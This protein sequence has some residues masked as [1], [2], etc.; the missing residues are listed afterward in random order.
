MNE[1][2]ISLPYK[3]ML[4][5]CRFVFR[6]FTK[7][8]AKGLEQTPMEGPL[9]IASNHISIFE[10]P[11]IFA[12]IPRQPVSTIAKAEYRDWIVSRLFFKGVDPVYVTRG[13]ADRTALKEILNRLKNKQALGIAP[14]GTRSK[15]KALIQ[16]KEGTAYLA[17][18]SGA[19]ILPLAVWGQEKIL[20][21]WTR[22]R[23]PT[24]YIRAAKPFKVENNPNKTRQENLAVNTEQLMHAIA[25]LLPPEYRG[26][27]AEA[28]QG[29]PEW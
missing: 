26:Y 15:N 27:Y 14:E 5:T 16:G 11:L 12:M 29:E 6:F 13:E 3:M 2:N 10:G 20:H 23:R 8:D 18:K 7:V 25:R 9:L 24:I 21:D 28:V 1:Q 4:A 17:L 22:L 19:W